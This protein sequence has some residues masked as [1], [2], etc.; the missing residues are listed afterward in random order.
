MARRRRTAPSGD[1]PVPHRDR[2]PR[3]RRGGRGRAV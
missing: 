1:R 3:H 2:R